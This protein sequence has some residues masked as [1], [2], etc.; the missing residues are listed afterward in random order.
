MLVKNQLNKV[1]T[2]D[3][4]YFIAKSHFEEDGTQNCLVFQPMYRYFIVFSITQCLEYVSEW[5]SKGW[6]NKTIKVISTSDNSLNP[7]LSYYDTKIRV[8]FTRGCLK[9]KISYTHGKIVN[10]YI[11]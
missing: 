9:P 6:S 5:K 1:K 11:F 3:S 8:K 7:T 2:F 10:I 4:S